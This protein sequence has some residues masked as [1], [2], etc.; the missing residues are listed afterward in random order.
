MAG[1][2]PRIPI[3]S[4]FDNKGV[5]EA[6]SSFRK[7]GDAAKTTAKAVGIL[8]AA[9]GAAALTIGKKAVDAASDLSESVNAVNV[10]F[11]EAADGILGLSEASAQAVGLSSREF[12]AFAVQFGA[13]SKQIA[14]AEGDVV[15]VTDELTTRIADFA[16]VMN[17]DVPDAAAVF[18]SS[19]AGETEPIR[20]F[21]DRKSV[22]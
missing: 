17:L 13:F 1:T 22:V 5:R 16:S 12:N 6:Q 4:S 15:G 7:L 11:G 21:G 10:T 19:L 3:V 20:R 9:F 2:Q 18:Q 14:G 8:S